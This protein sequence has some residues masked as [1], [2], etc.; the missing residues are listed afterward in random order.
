M[1]DKASAVPVILRRVEK[2]VPGDSLYLL[3]W[4][5]DRKLILEKQSADT[6]L[7][8]ERGFCQQDFIITHDKLKK[9]LKILLKRE[10]PRSKKIRTSMIIKENR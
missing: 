4:K 10:F 8:R 9:L 6:I 2:M 3:T 5:K 7:V 1:M